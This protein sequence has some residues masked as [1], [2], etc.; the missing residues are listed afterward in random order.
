MLNELIKF[1]NQKTQKNALH[2]ERFAQ[3]KKPMNAS[4]ARFACEASSST[5][6][7][8]NASH[9]TNNA[10][11]KNNNAS[12]KKKETT[13]NKERNNKKKKKKCVFGL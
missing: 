6:K 11:H 7:P 13:T 8:K 5:K 12:H 3:T 2:K 1:P 4:H 9:K 10:S